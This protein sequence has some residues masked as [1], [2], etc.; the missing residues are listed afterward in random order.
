[1]LYHVWVGVVGLVQ[2]GPAVRLDLAPHLCYKSVTRVLQEC[3]KS[4]TRVLQECYKSVT[5]VLQG[6]YRRVTRVLQGCYVHL[7][8]ATHLGVTRV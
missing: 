8:L 3:Y 6:F 4:V 2:E 7:D 5:R 1:M